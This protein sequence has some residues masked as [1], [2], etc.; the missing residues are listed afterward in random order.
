MLEAGPHVYLRLRDVGSQLSRGSHAHGGVGMEPHGTQGCCGARLAP[1][2]REGPGALGGQLALLLVLG[3]DRLRSALVTP[4]FLFDMLLSLC[5][6]LHCGFNRGAPSDAR[7]I[8]WSPQDL[9]WDLLW[10]QGL[11]R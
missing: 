7:F 8:C 11:Y 10:R 6:M 5:L 1:P 4:T 2:P 9:E 3:C